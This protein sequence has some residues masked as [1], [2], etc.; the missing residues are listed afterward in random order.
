MTAASCVV[1]LWL[2]ASGHHGF[3]VGILMIA[4]AA[5]CVPCT[6]H[7][8]LYSRVGALH[9]V[10]LAALAMVALHAALL[11]GAGGAKHS[12]G[13]GEKIGTADA[14]GGTELLLIIGLEILTA[15]LAA[16]LIARL[17]GRG[18]LQNVGGQ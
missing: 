14:S 15:M 8:W 17:R 6:V 2:A 16:T 7:I 5:V 11:F 10:A 18:Q 9:Q 3:W 13:S 4:L 12:H 1:H